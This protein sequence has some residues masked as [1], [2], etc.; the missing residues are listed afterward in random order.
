[1]ENEYKILEDI[2]EKAESDIILFFIIIAVVLIAFLLPLYVLIFKDRKANREIELKR[3]K[4]STEERNSRQDKYMEREKYI[5]E[6][7][8]A[9]TTVISELRTTLQ[10]NKEGNRNS[11]DR[12][13]LRLDE[14][15]AVA[16]QNK[17]MHKEALQLLHTIKADK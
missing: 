6:V 5:I 15:A 1:M 11:F 3:D 2:V 4:A 13:H 12:V 10:E 7:V 14:L 17:A 8:T 9:N 16:A